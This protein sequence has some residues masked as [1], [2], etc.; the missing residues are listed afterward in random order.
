MSDE[1]FMKISSNAEN[2]FRSTSSSKQ[3]HELHPRPQ[4]RSDGCSK[5][6]QLRRSYQPRGKTFSS[7]VIK[8]K[9]IAK[10]VPLP[11]VN[12]YCVAHT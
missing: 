8:D 5:F 4:P 12:N 11:R 6:S 9:E 3:Y 2:Y 7:E 1:H 10:K